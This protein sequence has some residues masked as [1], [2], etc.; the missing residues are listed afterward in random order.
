M[1][2]TR[3]SSIGLLLHVTG[4]LH[5]QQNLE[6]NPAQVRPVSPQGPAHL[7]RPRGD[8]GQTQMVAAA[9][10]GHLSLDD[11]P[12]HLWLSAA[13]VRD[14]QRDYPAAVAQPDG[15]ATGS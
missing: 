15:R 10:S 6:R 12:E 1:M 14:A 3:I 8:V 4:G 9:R 7:F 2:A 5:G 13:V 11:L